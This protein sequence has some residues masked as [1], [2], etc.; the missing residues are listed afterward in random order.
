MNV[1]HENV[2]GIDFSKIFYPSNITT[3]RNMS[4]TF[5][6]IGFCMQF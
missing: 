6:L 5:V 4:E 3:A 2:T 1:Y